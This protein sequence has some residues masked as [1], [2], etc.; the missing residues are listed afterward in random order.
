[1]HVIFFFSLVYQC[2]SFEVFLKAVKQ[3]KTVVTIGGENYMFETDSYPYCFNNSINFCTKRTRWG[4]GQYGNRF[5][6]HQPFHRSLI[7]IRKRLL[8]LN[9]QDICSPL[10]LCLDLEEKKFSSFSP[11]MKWLV[12]K[13]CFF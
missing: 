7:W 13:V 8:F 10:R 2:Y 9:H 5:S 1:M 6:Q 12:L 3:H 11:L 4:K